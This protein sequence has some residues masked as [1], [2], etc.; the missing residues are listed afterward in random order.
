MTRATLNN[1]FRQIVI[2]MAHAPGYQI[3]TYRTADGIPDLAH[4]AFGATFQDYLDGAF[5]SRR[6]YHAG[7]DENTFCGGYPALFVEAKDMTAPD[8]DGQEIRMEYY[9]V[10]VDK[11]PCD[12]CPPWTRS[13][14]TVSDAVL[15]MLRA[16]LKELYAYA[17]YEVDRDGT[18]TYEWMSAGRAAYEVGLGN[19]AD[20]I[21]D[22]VPD[23]DPDP[24][25]ISEW[26]NDHTTRGWMARL[27]FT[28]C[29][30][31]TLSFDYQT[32]VV[33]GLANTECPC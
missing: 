1:I 7:A 23:I 10:V 25:Q 3:D 33:P 28:L 30:P 6:F 8:L 12:D 17:L 11:I 5:W 26:W 32:P 14:T 29:E 15:A 4:Q 9:F 2:D 21:E 24:V 27:V 16:F 20:F 31:V 19:T 22:L 13:G 18:V